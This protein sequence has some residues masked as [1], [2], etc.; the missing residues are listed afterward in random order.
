MQGERAG[1]ARSGH[2]QAARQ[3]THGEE[4]DAGD[5]HARALLDQRDERID[6]LL[7]RHAVE[8]LVGEHQQRGHAEQAELG[9]RAAPQAVDHRGRANATTASPMGRS[10][11]P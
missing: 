4:E 11:L 9:P 6:R 5:H 3:P 8:V 7:A 1:P 2:R 10:T